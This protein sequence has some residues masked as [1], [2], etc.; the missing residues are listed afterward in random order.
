[1]FKLSRTVTNWNRLGPTGTD[2]QT[3]W[4]R[5]TDAT[6]ETYFDTNDYFFARRLFLN[7]FTYC[8]ADKL[9]Q[10]IVPG[11]KQINALF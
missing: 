10:K 1:M 8:L 9:L 7:A 4:L 3:G 6:T 5:W 2:W 11:T